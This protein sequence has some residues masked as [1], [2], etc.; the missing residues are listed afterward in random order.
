MNRWAKIARSKRSH[1]RAYVA[2]NAIAASRRSVTPTELC[3]ASVPIAAHVP[4]GWPMVTSRERSMFCSKCGTSA[5]DNDSFCASCGAQIRASGASK[6]WKKFET[7]R[8][9]SMLPA[10]RAPS[11]SPNSESPLAGFLLASGYI[12][13]AITWLLTT[14]FASL[15]WGI[16]GALAAFFIPPLDIV[17][18]F[19]LG[20]WQ[21]GIPAIALVIL[22][23]ALTKD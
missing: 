4:A 13:G 11:L 2:K 16:W 21:L 20:T 12:L 3:S 1:Q 19:M 14:Y 7:P 18:M 22:G 17:F 8:P 10:S 9:E 15:S 23:A 5:S 6:A